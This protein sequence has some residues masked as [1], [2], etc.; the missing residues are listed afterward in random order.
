[1][2]GNR[3]VTGRYYELGAPSGRRRDFSGGGKVEATPQHRGARP[4]EIV[5]VCR[6][7]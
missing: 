4:N 6:Y 5:A 3:Q 1:M 2:R 7:A